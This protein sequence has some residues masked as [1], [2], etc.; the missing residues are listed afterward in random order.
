MRIRSMT[1][2]RSESGSVEMTING[3]KI[4]IG[5]WIWRITNICGKKKEVYVVITIWPRSKEFSVAFLVYLEKYGKELHL[6]DFVAKRSKL[7]EQ[8]FEM[9]YC[10]YEH[11][12]YAALQCETLIRKIFRSSYFSSLALA[13]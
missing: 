3:K 5:S 2:A 13:V 10:V 12:A 11:F 1:G 9:T 7:I 8:E 4:L 6:L